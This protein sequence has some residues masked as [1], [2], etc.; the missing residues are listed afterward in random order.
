MKPEDINKNSEI[1]F[2]AGEIKVSDLE[3]PQKDFALSSNDEITDVN[4]F[5]DKMNIVNDGNSVNPE[6]AGNEVDSLP[7]SSEKDID[8]S[9]GEDQNNTEANSD[10]AEPVESEDGN[11]ESS[12]ESNDSSSNSSNR[13]KKRDNNSK[14]EKPEDKKD[15]KKDDLQKNS[16]DPQME[17]N[18][19]HNPAN[20]GYDP[21]KP[22]NYNNNP[23]NKL[24]NPP[25][26]KP[27]TPSGTPAGTP[28][29]TP[30]P[31]PPTTPPPVAAGATA[32]AGAT[33]AATAT[34]T[35]AASGAAAAGGGAAAAGGSASVSGVAAVVSSPIF[36]I[37]LAILLILFVLLIVMIALSGSTALNQAF[38][39][40]AFWWP[41]GSIEEDA[42]GIHSGPPA[43]TGVSSP[44]GPRKDPMGS[45]KIL[46]HNGIDIPAPQNTPIIAIKDG[47]VTRAVNNCQATGCSGY[48]NVVAIDH[49]DGYVSLY[50]HAYVIDVEIGD[51]VVQGQRIGGVGTTGNSTG[52]HIHFEII[53]NGVNVDPLLFVDPENPR[54]V[55][56]TGASNIVL[57]GTSL[58]LPDF[59]AAAADYGDIVGSADYNRYIVPN[60]EEIYFASAKYNINPELVIVRAVVEG[61]SPGGGTNNLWGIQCYNSCVSCCASYSSLDAGIKAFADIVNGYGS[62]E[63]AFAKYAYIGDYWYNP[64]SWSLG[65]CKYFPYVSKYLSEGRQAEVANACGGSACSGGSCLS[66]TAEDQQAYTSFQLEKMNSV[67]AAI[68]G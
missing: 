46:P 49:G 51:Q 15:V 59:G 36:W 1:E 56:A 44:F 53:E 21:N 61:Y 25:A 4:S 27:A 43:Y 50:A 35:T 42:A 66:T 13:N 20:N 41:V 28:P 16:S 32:G 62:I 2:E 12:S 37:V 58:S 48:G 30:A 10:S 63:A 68:F 5:E 47:V 54:P 29:T 6:V 18:R 45:G 19:Q 8:K 57:E 31:V 60:L 65:G 38:G 23:S 24:N 9:S 55:G 3:Q 26:S 7:A 40:N 39:N 64:G 22:G 34:T 67:H 14:E 52:N 11:G 17:G 33:T